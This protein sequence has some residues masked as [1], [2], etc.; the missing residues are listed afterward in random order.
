MGRLLGMKKEINKIDKIEFS[1]INEY[2][3]LNQEIGK[4]EGQIIDRIDYIL[5][6]MFNLFG[7][8][9]ETW[10]FDGAGEGQMGNL[11]D[12]MNNHSINI[13]TECDRRRYSDVIYKDIVIIDKDNKE[14]SYEGDLPKRWLF[15]DF[16]AEL[17]E[18]KRKYEEVEAAR[19]IKEK[20]T[21]KA[22]K[23]KDQK[24]AEAAKS[25]LSKEELAALKRTIK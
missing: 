5:Y 24:L 18:G 16:E 11:S 10:Y 3:R 13:I 12:N 4:Y 17:V 20:E 15:E 25:K 19:K 23:E 6:F 22:K 2:N 21:R 7:N 1:T 9:L 8:N 14:W